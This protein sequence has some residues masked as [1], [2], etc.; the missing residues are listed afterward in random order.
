MNCTF[1]PQKNEEI[2]RI[3]HFF[4]PENQRYLIK[5]LIFKLQYLFIQLQCFFR[6]HIR[7]IMFINFS[8]RFRLLE[9]KYSH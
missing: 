7:E 2:I 3:K 6:I 1:L 5:V 4:K 8:I 9:D